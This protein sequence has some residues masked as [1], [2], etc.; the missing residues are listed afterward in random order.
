MITRRPRSRRDDAVT[1]GDHHTSR[2]LRQRWSCVLREGLQRHVASRRRG[3]RQPSYASRPLPAASRPMGGMKPPQSPCG[4]STRSARER[5]TSWSTSYGLGRI[6]EAWRPYTAT[7]S[8]ISLI[9]GSWLPHGSRIAG[10]EPVRELYFPDRF[11]VPPPKYRQGMTLGKFR[12]KQTRS[13]GLKRRSGRDR[14][15][16]Q[17]SWFSTSRSCRLREVLVDRVS[18]TAPSKISGSRNAC[19]SLWWARWRS[20]CASWRTAAA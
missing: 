5:A 16:C 20:D 9:A 14:A 10:T 4:C 3:R 13:G 15:S 2:Q 8:H 6:T 17:L 19:M 7:G 12:C 11:P 18:V 1:H